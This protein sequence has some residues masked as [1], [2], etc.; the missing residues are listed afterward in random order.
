VRVLQRLPHVPRNALPA[1]G[2]RREDFLQAHAQLRIQTRRVG[3]TGASGAG[4]RAGGRALAARAGRALASRAGSHKRRVLSAGA[5]P[6]AV[7]A[8]TSPNEE[9]DSIS[10]P[11]ASSTHFSRPSYS[12]SV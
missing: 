9:P 4:G 12:Q 2:R 11:Q 8:R 3:R 7:L 6:G 10:T 1:A 5:R